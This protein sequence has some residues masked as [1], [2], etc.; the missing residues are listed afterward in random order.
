MS[1][2]IFNIQDDG[3][4]IEMNAAPFAD[5]DRFQALLES[6]PNLLGG[7]Q[8]HSSEPRRWLL[9]NREMGIPDQKDAAN[10]W[11]LDHLFLDQEAIPTL[12]EVKRSSDTRLRREVVG[13]VLDYAANAVRYWTLDKIVGEFKRQCEKDGIDAEQRLIDFLG[14]DDQD[15]GEFWQSVKT[16]LQA[17]RIRMLFVADVIPQELQSIVEFLNTQMD[18]AEVLAV[19]L[20]HFVGAGIKTLV[21][22]VIGRTAEAA[23]R[24]NTTAGKRKR[25]LTHE[26]LQQIAVEHGV[27]EPYAAL[28]QRM[29]PYFK[30]VSTTL[31]NVAFNDRISGVATDALIAKL[32]PAESD[33]ERGVAFVVCIDRM[34][35]VLNVDKEQVSES[36]QDIDGI[37]KAEDWTGELMQGFLKSAADI[38][39]LINLMQ[40]A[41]DAE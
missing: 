10:R 21:P 4:L 36:L 20:Q 26:Q 17:G 24:K 8:M 39:P 28:V 19:E 5:E 9:I 30:R 18:P 31:S 16:N 25:N 2:Q 15:T 33:P 7:D 34:S 41:R 3:T 23:Q 1:G 6:Y 14:D 32:T 35:D 12:V 40:Q 13:Q 37:E 22:R 27:G 11:S 29:T 38:D